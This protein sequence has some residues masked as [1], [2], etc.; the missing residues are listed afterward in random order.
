[1]IP[2]LK[3]LKSSYRDYTKLMHLIKLWTAEDNIQ[4]SDR[5]KVVGD[6]GLELSLEEKTD[7]GKQRWSMYYG[8]ESTTQDRMQVSAAYSQYSEQPSR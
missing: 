1:M 8:K 2:V 4:Y 3:K 6:T 7:L 5:E